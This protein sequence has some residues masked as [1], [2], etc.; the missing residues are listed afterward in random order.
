MRHNGQL[1]RTLARSSW[2]QSR[3]L[4]LIYCLYR[5]GMDHQCASS[6]RFLLIQCVFIKTYHVLSTVSLWG[7]TVFGRWP[8]QRSNFQGYVRDSQCTCESG[9]PSWIVEWRVV[10]HAM[11]RKSPGDSE[12]WAPSQT[13]LFYSFSLLPYAYRYGCIMCVC[14]YVSAHVFARQCPNTTGSMWR[15]GV[16]L[17]C[18]S[19]LSPLCDMGPLACCIPSLTGSWPSRNSVS[20]FH[21]TLGVLG[22]EICSTL[23]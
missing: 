7:P 10:S 9:L 4:T 1:W 16:N 12:V 6:P 22:L 15:S 18:Q 20:T 23:P 17:S 5:Q 11:N 3:P 2:K 19:L 8:R 13:S 21:L 14:S